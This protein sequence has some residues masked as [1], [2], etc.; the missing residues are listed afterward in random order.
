MLI[1]N[2]FDP[3]NFFNRNNI[4]NFKN[5][6]NLLNNQTINFQAT[7]VPNKP[8]EETIECQLCQ[9]RILNRV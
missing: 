3:G 1:N 6:T 7:T 2:S 8:P 9:K 4:T 5:D